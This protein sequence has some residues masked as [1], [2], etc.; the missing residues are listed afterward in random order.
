MYSMSAPAQNEGPSPASTTTRTPSLPARSSKMRVSSP[1]KAWL[2]ALWVSGLASETVVT[3]P[4]SLT[5][6][7][8]YWLK[9]SSRLVCHPSAPARFPGRRVPVPLRR[10]RSCGRR[11]LVHIPMPGGQDL[12][13]L[14]RHGDRVLVLRGEGPVRGHYGPA[15]SQHPYLPAAL[16]DHRL[17]GEDHALPQ[18]QAASPAPEVLDVGL[19]V[20]L[21]ANAV[22]PELPHHAVTAEL[23]HL[24]DRR[25]N[26]PEPCA[27]PHLRHASLKALLRRIKQPS[28]PRG[29]FPH[30]VRVTGVPDP[31][32]QQDPDVDA[33]DVPPA[34]L[35]ARRDTVY[36][37]L[38]HGGADGRW[39]RRGG[40][41][42]LVASVR[43]LGAAGEQDVP[44][45]AVQLIQPDAGAYVGHKRLEGAGDQVACQPEALDLFPAPKDYHRPPCLLHSEHPEPGL[46]GGRVGRGRQAEGEDR[47]G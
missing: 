7:C 39:E 21:P 38:V 12:A 1:I 46:L 4:S 40:G 44:D 43:R 2:R 30:G 5:A 11:A 22:P 33:D 16:V 27:W 31:A 14:A 13:P 41:R 34:Q 35:P 15:V 20:Q 8:S 26:V 24:L 47:S 29:H 42:G 10:D 3:R 19:L 25:A 37:L 9:V 32:V 6:R 17:D 28:R 45:G 36:D 23:R 18:A